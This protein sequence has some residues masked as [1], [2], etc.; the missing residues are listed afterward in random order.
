MEEKNEIFN[1]E[2]EHL[3][4]IVELLN[5]QIA[6]AKLEFETLKHKIIGTKEAERGAHFTRQSL[7]NLYSDTVVNLEKI[8]DSPYFGKFTFKDNDG[9]RDIYIGKKSII[10]KEAKL[11]TYDWRSPICSMYY[12]Y[13]I[14]K[15]QYTFNDVVE[16]GEILKKLQ[17]D[18][19][20]GKLLKLD[21]H[22][23]MSDD[24]IL[25]SYLG[26]TSNSRLKSI[27]ATIQKEQ[28]HIIRNT[29]GKNYIIQGVAGSGK[30]TV[31]LHRMAYLIYNYSKNVKETQFMILG[32]NKYFLNYISEALPDLD[33]EDI[34]QT[35]FEDIAAKSIKTKLKLT[36][37]NDT[38][39]GVLDGK[40]DRNIVK[41]KSSLKYLEAIKEFV[42]AYMVHNLSTDIEYY[43]LNLCESFY[44]KR[45]CEL[46]PES[47][48]TGNFTDKIEQFS[49]QIVKEI[50]NKS[51][52]LCHDLWQKYRS[53]YLALPEGSKERKELSDFI[54]I[55]KEN[56]KS[57]CPKQIKEYF[58]F[59]KIDI[60]ELYKLFIE[61]LDYMNLPSNIDINVLK[62][63]T[64]EKIEKKELGSD[65][66]TGLTYMC[67][68]MRG[69]KNY[70]PYIHLV[71]DEAQ[72]LSAAQYYILQKLFPN[73]KFDIF[74]DI[75]QSIYDYESIENWDELNNLVFNG[76]AQLLYL[77]KSYR[78]SMQIS[79]A[80]NNVLDVLG[81]TTA[82]CVARDGADVQVTDITC[83]NPSNVLLEQI[84][85]LLDKKHTNIAI[86]CK[87]SFE[88]NKVYNLLKKQ[89][90]DVHEITENTKTYI[91]GVTIIPS[92]LAK[93]LEFDA[94]IINDAN[95]DIY[96]DSPLDQK[97]LYVAM[98]RAMH[99]LRI[100]YSNEITPSLKKLVP[101]NENKVM[102]KTFNN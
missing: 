52:D 27:V 35:T 6:E 56:I 61:S 99:E 83:Y 4:K 63:T 102:K 37:K 41:Y 30:T 29:M 48:Q 11:V 44:I 22:D 67:Y 38:L 20:G 24:K 45:A 98:T 73:A 9:I 43:G 90:L 71:V 68:L 76:E 88:S 77:D 97:L 74:G 84:R 32:P 36:T 3:A 100:N 47:R 86:I 7:M 54:N 34:S 85:D 72:D 81:Y 96:T 39:Q 8:V 2:E 18:I 80:A 57:G 92:Y 28:N 42:N 17:F 31:A 51:E 10:D 62:N 93:G 14:G 53:E 50:K 26:E 64:L 60:L 25:I 75:N 23:S 40:I 91:G 15:A 87:D 89:G 13:N 1:I 12:D 49:K 58:N 46:L 95:S 69:I 94:V 65:D 55:G 70:E 16:S 19:K 79:N 59:M 101:S 78:T 5:K 21:E 82:E 33:V 66:L